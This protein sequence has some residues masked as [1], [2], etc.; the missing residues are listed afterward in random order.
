MLTTVVLKRYGSN[1][2]TA[3][4]PAVP[5]YQGQGPTR[6]AAMQSL[7][8]AIENPVVEVEVTSMDIDVSRQAKVEQSNPWLAMA[9]IFADDP[10]LMPMLEEIYAE[11]DKDRPVD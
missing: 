3:T 5:G 10:E 6:E 11:R 9:G 8:A 7:R 2:Y 1:G 4:A